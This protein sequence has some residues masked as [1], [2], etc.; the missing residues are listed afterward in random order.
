MSR[1][2]FEP[3]SVRIVLNVTPTA[4]AEAAK[5]AKTDAP[6]RLGQRTFT[7]Q[8]AAHAFAALTAASPHKIIATGD[9]IVVEIPLAEED[10]PPS[11]RAEWHRL[12]A[13]SERPPALEPAPQR[14]PDAPAS[15]VDEAT[16]PHTSPGTT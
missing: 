9:E 13:V 16:R 5:R 14:A 11:I 6:L 1:I 15:V 3:G 10:I 7:M 8:D 12:R 2:V 4:W